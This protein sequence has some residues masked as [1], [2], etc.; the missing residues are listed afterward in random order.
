MF[1]QFYDC[2]LRVKAL[3][4]SRGGS[5]LEGFATK[6]FQAGY[7]EITARGHIRAAEHLIYWSGGE[8]TAIPA[9]RQ[10]ELI[11]AFQGAIKC[12]RDWQGAN[13]ECNVPGCS[14]V[15]PIVNHARLFHGNRNPLGP[16]GAE[17]V[18]SGP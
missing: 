13:G 12:E 6:L 9:G 5:L 15:C 4:D 1:E 14:S 11:S 3:R 16:P 8:S 2:P 17:Q 7:A 18:A 10:G